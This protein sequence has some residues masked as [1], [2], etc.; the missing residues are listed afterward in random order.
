MA[1]IP[2]DEAVANESEIHDRPNLFLDEHCLNTNI[3][4]YN[5]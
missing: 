2:L 4:Q 1:Y 5:I 3:E